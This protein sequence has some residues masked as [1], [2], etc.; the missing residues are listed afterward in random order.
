MIRQLKEKSPFIEKNIFRSVE[1]VNLDT[2]IAY[3]DGGIKH[4]FLDGY[5]AKGQRIESESDGK[6]SEGQGVQCGSDGKA[7]LGQEDKI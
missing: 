5:K 4:H 3:K 6:A 2:I 1:N 7:Q